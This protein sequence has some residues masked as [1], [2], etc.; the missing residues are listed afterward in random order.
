[1]T[2]TY[3]KQDRHHLLIS[4]ERAE[5]TA[6]AAAKL[7]IQLTS[8]DR[9]L[10]KHKVVFVG[11]FSFFFFSS[12]PPPFLVMTSVR[13][14]C[15]CAVFARET[16]DVVRGGRDVEE[17][18]AKRDEGN[19]NLFVWKHYVHFSELNRRTG[20]TANTSS[21]FVVDFVF[22]SRTSQYYQWFFVNKFNVFDRSIGSVR[23]TSEWMSLTRFIRSEF[24]VYERY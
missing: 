21:R 15:L 18:D 17:K 14:L 7:I 6:A 2:R 4:I 8:T 10:V 16:R 19:A 22:N 24:K 12:P 9:L 5:T 20:K 3:G 23:P 1:M 13:C 11:V